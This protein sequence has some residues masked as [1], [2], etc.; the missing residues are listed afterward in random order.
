MWL[1]QLSWPREA[2]LLSCLHLS[3]V[4][5]ALLLLLREAVAFPRLFSELRWDCKAPDT[6]P[7]PALVGTRRTDRGGSLLDEV[8]LEKCRYP[9]AGLSWRQFI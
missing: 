8:A 9:T 3:S 6:T 1:G 4:T 7:G 5:N 2:L